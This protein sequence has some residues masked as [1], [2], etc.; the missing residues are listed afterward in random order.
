MRL[1][2]I[3]DNKPSFDEYAITEENKRALKDL[4][5]GRQIPWWSPAFR[6]RRICEAGIGVRERTAPLDRTTDA[7]SDPAHLMVFFAPEG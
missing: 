3:Y 4:D 1:L 2:R 6:R 7:R 5:D